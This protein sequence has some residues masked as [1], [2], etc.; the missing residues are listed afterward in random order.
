MATTE[1]SAWCDRR[2]VRRVH[3]LRHVSLVL[4]FAGGFSS[5]LAGASRAREIVGH[6]PLALVLLESS[7]ASLRLP[8]ASR[9]M[10][11]LEGRYISIAFVARHGIRSLGKNKVWI[12]P[13]HSLSLLL[14]LALLLPLT[15]EVNVAINA[16]QACLVVKVHLGAGV[17]SSV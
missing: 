13:L 7:R 9:I 15:N 4:R 14:P 16:R 1:R 10:I 11:V 2:V 6:R 3:I 17:W 5:L 12:H 8:L